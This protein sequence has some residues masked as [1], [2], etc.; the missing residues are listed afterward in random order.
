MKNK[1]LKNLVGFMLAGVCMFS[2]CTPISSTG[3]NSS[4]STP[5][6]SDST[7]TIALNKTEISLLVG[8]TETLTVS[9]YSGEITWSSTNGA[10]ATVSGGVVTG[11]SE[12]TTYI[13]AKCGDDEVSCK[14]IITEQAAVLS[15]LVLDKAKTKIGK[16]ATLTVTAYIQTGMEFEKLDGEDVTWETSNATVATVDNGVVTGVSVGEV[17]ITASYEKD[18]EKLTQTVSLN[19]VSISYYKVYWKGEEVTVFNPVSVLVADEYFG[20]TTT[21]SET[22]TIKEVDWKTGEEKPVTEEITW[23]SSDAAVVTASGTT[24]TGGTK[25]AEAELIA[26]I[27]NH[28][29]ARVDGDYDER[30]NEQA[31]FRHV[32]GAC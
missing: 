8:A 13:T 28:E 21:S 9:G 14:V 5:P 19:V 29:I 22:V 4:E 30:P 32:D 20:A 1:V 17:A 11:V 18:G 15:T 16:G 2:A 6:S 24:I 31:C 12:G 7:L 27:G 10:I 25:N 26:F 3:S 23:K